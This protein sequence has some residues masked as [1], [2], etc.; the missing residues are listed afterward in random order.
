[1]PHIRPKAGRLRGKHQESGKECLELADLRVVAGLG[2]LGEHGQRP[3]CRPVIE[4]YWLH[5]RVGRGI[6]GSRRAAEDTAP[7]NRLWR[8]TL[9]FPAADR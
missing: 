1:M 2:Q 5:P 9:D 8:R 3:R 6:D 4:G 7:A